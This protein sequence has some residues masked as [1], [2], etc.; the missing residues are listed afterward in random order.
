MVEQTSLELVDFATIM[1]D[2]KLN[3]YY[4][5]LPESIIHVMKGEKNTQSPGDKKRKFND[6]GSPTTVMNDDMNNEWKLRANETWHM[7]WH[8]TGKG[9]A[10]STGAKPCLKFDIRGSCFDDC[11]NKR[12]HKKLSGNHLKLTNNFIQKIRENLN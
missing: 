9:L 6:Q 8:K 4:C 2:L 7:W 11:T 12:S 10:L 5:D 3:R 1:L